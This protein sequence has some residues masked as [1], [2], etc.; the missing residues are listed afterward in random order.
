MEQELLKKLE[1][2]GRELADIRRMVN[3]IR[4]YFLWTLIGSLVLFILPLIGLAFV[5]PQFLA[6]YGNTGGGL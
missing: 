2:Q 4:R 6:T 5:V 3:Q 1:E